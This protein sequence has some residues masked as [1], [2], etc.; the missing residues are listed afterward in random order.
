LTTNFGGYTFLTTSNLNTLLVASQT[1]APALIP[2]LFPG[3]SVTSSTTNFGV[4]YTPI[5]ATTV[6]VLPGTP[7]PGV[8]NISVVTN[9]Y[10][11]TPMLLYSDTF[12]NIITN[13]NL[14]NTP[15]LFLNG[16]N[17]VLSYYTN[18]SASLVTVSLGTLIGA[19]YPAPVVT[20][21]TV[22]TITLT[23]A[24][25]GEYFAIPTN[26]CGWTFM[27]PQPGG[28]PLT[29]V[30]ATTN[31]IASVTN[32]STSV[33]NAV[34][35]VGSV[36][37]VTYFTN[38][39]YVAA[40][41]ICGQTATNPP[42]LYEGIGQVQFV[43][44]D[45]DSILGQYWQ[46]VTNKYTMTLVTNSQTVVQYFQRVVTTPD[47]LFRAS[48]MG[49]AAIYNNT[50]TFDVNHIL[51]NLAGPGTILPA[52][53]IT[54]NKSGPL[55][56]N[57]NSGGLTNGTP[58]FTGLPGNDLTNSFFTDY[59]V[60]AS[61]DGT[62]NA[63]VVYPNG[64]SVETLQNQVLIQ[65]TP[66]TLPGDYFSDTPH[67]PVTF[68]ATGGAFTQPYTWSASGLPSGMTLVSNPDST[69]TL[70]GTPAQSGT[71]DFI[72]TMTDYVG[73]SV[74]FGYSITIQ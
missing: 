24:A 27:S 61:Y 73:R 70:S 48:D 60:W 74:H 30:V 16:A 2:G 45:Y 39:T 54:Y 15:N 32:T 20:N 63:P 19:P 65:V 56:Y 21:T 7:Y 4:L 67:G 33:S 66:A 31:L 9:G 13:A 47:F 18:M 69:A 40:P 5:V 68:T 36:S 29:N 17:V 72:L 64:T 12:G 44:A 26:Q 8:T 1:N 23:N 34:G 50:L 6:T 49:T 57:A 3:V 53:T 35:F 22:Q 25:S 37:Q 38:H 43:E 62:T 52:T 58:Y 10:V 41:V 42:G 46:P 51:P 71:F 14:T 11:S 59:Y 55:Y 28:Y